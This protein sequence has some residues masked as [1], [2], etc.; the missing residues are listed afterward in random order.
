MRA[1]PCSPAWLLNEKRLTATR[2]FLPPWAVLPGRVFPLD[3][4]GGGAGAAPFRLY[5]RVNLVF[6]RFSQPSGEGRKADRL[7]SRLF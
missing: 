6:R 3:R 5:R 7:V 1:E 4:R 2:F